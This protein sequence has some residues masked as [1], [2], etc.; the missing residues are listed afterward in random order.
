MGYSP[1]GCKESDT[2]YRLNNKNKTMTLL[3][4]T[5]RQVATQLCLNA[6]RDG[7]LTARGSWADIQAVLAENILTIQRPK[8]RPKP[9]I[10]KERVL[11]SVCRAKLQLRT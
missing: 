1:R 5:P 9:S 2:S 4:R 10:L 11:I 3:Y 7:E 6:S 8:Q